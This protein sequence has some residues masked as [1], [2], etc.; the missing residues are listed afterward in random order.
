M[1]FHAAARFQL[2]DQIWIM[3]Y[4]ASGELSLPPYGLNRTKPS[5]KR[6]GS[7]PISQPSRVGQARHQSKPALD[8]IH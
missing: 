3:T 5:S 6:H 1:P 4:L 7:L 2:D 8:F